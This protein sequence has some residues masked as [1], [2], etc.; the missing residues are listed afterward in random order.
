MFLFKLF[1]GYCSFDLAV[2]GNQT[3]VAFYLIEKGIDLKK[4]INVLIY[5]LIE[6]INY[7]YLESF[8]VLY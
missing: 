8:I 6:S 3:K 7:Y 4:H 2:I 5:F 1:Y